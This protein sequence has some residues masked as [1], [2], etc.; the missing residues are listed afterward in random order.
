MLTTV[1][2]QKEWRDFFFI[3]ASL[4]SCTLPLITV[5]L[6]LSPSNNSCSPYKYALAAMDLELTG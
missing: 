2:E 6:M 1:N 5:F 4:T 3:N